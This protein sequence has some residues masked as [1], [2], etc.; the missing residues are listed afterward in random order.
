MPTINELL[1]D[2]GFSYAV[3]LQ[4]AETVQSQ[5][6]LGML[7]E[8][9]VTLRTQIIVADIDSLAAGEPIGVRLADRT[10]KRQEALIKQAQAS[11]DRTYGDI[12]EEHPSMLLSIASMSA[13]TA[14]RMLD[15]VFTVNIVQPTLTKAD[16][17]ALTNDLLIQGK[18]AQAWWETQ[19][20][21]TQDSYAREIRMGVA[22]GESTDKL[23]ARIIGKPTGKITTVIQDGKVKKIKEYAG[24]VMG[25]SKNEADS[26]VRTSAQSTANA[27]LLETYQDN[28]DILNGVAA[29]VTLDARTTLT[30]IARDGAEWDMQGNPLPSSSRQEPFPGPPPWHWRCRSVLTPITRSWEQLRSNRD[31]PARQRKALDTVP[32]SQRSSM[33]GRVPA[34]LDYEQWLKAKPEKFQKEVLGPA[35]WRLWNDGKITAAQLTDFSGNPLSV[36]EL[37]ALAA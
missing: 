17:K 3:T 28:A 15:S 2:Q 35:R 24:G 1:Q 27:A 14:T 11:I 30:C 13:K 33:D 7:E 6:I 23:V 12:K 21:K 8:L 25:V 4:R 16:L 29:H 9:S 10:R 31:L 26:L 22:A 20:A 34:K 5:R 32:A 18:P 37:E 19:D 36:A